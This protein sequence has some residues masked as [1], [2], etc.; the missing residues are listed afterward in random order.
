MESI[1]QIAGVI[2]GKEAAMMVAEGVKYL[3]FPLR[4]PD[5]R[6]D[7][8]EESA[9]SIIAS[10]GN[11]TTAVVITYLGDASEIS[12]FCWEMGAQTVQLHGSVNESEL[13]RLRERNPELEIFK[14]LIVREENL[15]E[16]EVEIS[17]TA[18]YVSAYITD[19]FDPLTGRSGATGKVHDWTVSAK[20]VEL[21]PRP[22]ILA[23]GLTPWNVR[24]AILQ[25]RPAGVDSHTGVERADGRKD[26]ALVRKFVA[27]AQDAFHLI[28][29]GFV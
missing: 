16:L 29:N 3:G 17:K 15:S 26:R 21:S 10:L 5:G 19:T 2:D 24:E 4:L 13:K 22:V 28:N 12:S 27:E 7:L 8:S 20:L 25:V 18:S 9:R 11:E 23:G 1:L 14:S 6:E